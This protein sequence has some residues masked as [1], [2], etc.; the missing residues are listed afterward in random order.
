MEIS[1]VS[2]SR[3]Q[4]SSLPRLLDVLDQGRE[5]GDLFLHAFWAGQLMVAFLPQGQSLPVEVATDATRPLRPSRHGHPAWWALEHQLSEVLWAEPP[6]RLRLAGEGVHDMPLGPVYRDSGEALR[7]QLGVLG[8]DIHHV[9]LR[10]G[11]KVRHVRDLLSGRPVADALLIAERVTGTSPVAHAWAFSSAVEACWDLT[12]PLP[13][14]AARAML[15]EFERLTSHVGDMAL[16]AQAT[17]T[18]TAAADLFRLKELV[19]RRNWAW[20][21][22]R[23]LRGALVPGGVKPLAVPCQDIVGYLSAWEQEF[24]HV[25]R[26]LQ[27]TPSFL[28]RLHGAGRIPEDI[29]QALVPIGPV[30]KSGGYGDDWRWRGPAPG[31]AE[32]VPG[33]QA[34]TLTQPDAFG[35]WWVRVEEVRQSLAILRRLAA[36]ADASLMPPPRAVVR[37]TAYGLAE[38]P[39][40]RIVYRVHL[41]DAAHT[42]RVSLSTASARNWPA[43]PPALEAGNILQD[44]PIIEA[45][46]GLAVSALDL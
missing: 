7:Y 3:A 10:P 28:D 41:Q 44:F 12:V 9:N 27:R 22:H 4:A 39:R 26:S 14:S 36:I 5:R 46:F 31:Y 11:F 34:V 40:G 42:G 45:S 1:T 20:T 21:G 6:H 13:V 37:S 8:D 29:L 16:L 2:E 32:V 38:G 24:E 33:M 18:I 15:A 30:G 43:V 25:I 35:R 23:Y 19:L 17:G